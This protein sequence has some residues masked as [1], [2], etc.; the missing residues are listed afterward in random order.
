MNRP[1][2]LGAVASRLGVLAFTAAGVLLTTQY[3]G[4]SGQGTIALLQ[5]GMLIAGTVN[6]IVAG[7]AVVHLQRTHPLRTLLAPGHLWLVAASFA[8]VAAEVAL[9][10][11]PGDKWLPV[12]LFAWLQGVIVFHGQIAIATQQFRWHNALQLLQTGLLALAL[13]VCY[14]V[15]GIHRIEGFLVA[16]GSAL[17]ITVLASLP[18]LRSLPHPPLAPG[19]RWPWRPLLAQG[20]LAQVGSLL[21]LLTQRLNVRLLTAW[22]P[23]GTGLASAGVYSVAYLGM[24]AMWTLARGWAPVVHGKIAALPGPENRDARHRL[25]RRMLALTWA[26]TLPLAALAAFLPD[27]AYQAVFGLAGIQP[28]LR[29][30][31]PAVMAGAGASILAHHLSGVGAHHVNAW[32]SG[33]GLALLVACGAWWIPEHGAVGAAWAASVAGWGQFLGQTLSYNRLR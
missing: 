1:L 16:L 17:G 32:T 13:L 9:D 26:A 24:E 21:Q 5:L 18:L 19:G 20:S 29:A 28:V 8:T 33:L 7:G 30:L 2:L 23:A 14:R 3:L 11:I 22:L 27:E 15:L 6:G 10:L 25:T 31:F 12:S 4:A